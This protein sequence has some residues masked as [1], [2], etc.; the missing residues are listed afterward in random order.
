MKPSFN[1]RL[2]RNETLSLQNFELKSVAS[3]C[4]NKLKNQEKTVFSKAQKKT[5]PK[6]GC[7]RSLKFLYVN[8]WGRGERCF[9]FLCFKD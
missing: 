9:R 7:I 8:L 6:D 2:Q 3:L 4:T 1:L 5:A